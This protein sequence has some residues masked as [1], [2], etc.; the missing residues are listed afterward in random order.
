MSYETRIA[1][2]REQMTERGVDVLLLSVG[3]D[4]PY[5]TGYEAMPLERL[6][7]FVLP[8][9]GDAYLVVPRLEA[10]RVERRP[11]LFEVVPWNETDDPVELVAL[12]TGAVTAAA[13]GDH[14][15][16]RFVLDL[17]RALPA[18]RFVRAS[19][20]TAPI[21]MVKEADEIAALQAAA[22]AVD[23]IAEEMRAW[24]FLGRT[25]LD[26]HRELV[27]RMLALGHERANFAIVAAGAHAASPHHE[28]S[29]D[30]VI[31]EGE[32]VLC[33][34]GGTMRGYC[35]DI[36]RMFHVGEPPNEVR[37]VY[38]VLQEA[39]EAGV[40]AAT[41]GTACEDVDA[42]AR[43]VIASAGY[44]DRFVHRVGHGIGTEAHEDP[45]MVSGNALALVPGHAFSV[46]PGIYIDG[47]YGM[48][49]ED[50]VV[51]TNDGPLRLNN[52][53]RDIAVVT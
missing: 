29:P 20:V 18:T 37:D 44:G 47:R 53:A 15:W 14:T 21:R 8:R 46:E 24:T 42:A 34:F 39:Q 3:P 52:A 25:E 30:R 5:L 16:A 50:I 6:T 27:E 9:A 26:V 12:I 43:R 31:G 36:T 51:A 32:I 17:Q 33:D 49:L 1:R 19:E 35:S 7:M 23:R 40:R 45:Y 2:V 41:I 22:A 4:L 48:R 28:P 13:V 10:P 11:D 38:E